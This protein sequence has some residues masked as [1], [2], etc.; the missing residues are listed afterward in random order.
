MY[1]SKLLSGVKISSAQVELVAV[2]TV[3]DKSG[4]VTFFRITGEPLV[5]WI[6]E[7]KADVVVIKV[8]VIEIAVGIAVNV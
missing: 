2:I 7:I 4:C 1:V 8:D 6:V 3:T 5:F